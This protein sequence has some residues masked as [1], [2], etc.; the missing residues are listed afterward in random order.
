MD[1]L[2]LRVSLTAVFVLSTAGGGRRV[3]RTDPTGTQ[4]VPRGTDRGAGMEVADPIRSPQT[5]CSPASRRIA[6]RPFPANDGIST[7][8]GMHAS[9]GTLSD[10]HC[11]GRTPVRS[12]Q[13]NCVMKTRIQ[14]RVPGINTVAWAGAKLEGINDVKADFAQVPH[15]ASGQDQECW[16][17]AS[18]ASLSQVDV[19]DRSLDS[20]KIRIRSHIRHFPQDT[21]QM[22]S[23]ASPGRPPTAHR[24]ESP[25]ARLR[26]SGGARPRLL[27]SGENCRFDV[28]YK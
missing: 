5:H 26:H 11:P 13:G 7:N 3:K 16:C 6:F 25:C 15:I 9:R 18:T 22:S 2:A 24:E 10:P 17:R 1:V 20:G 8:S 12:P 21:L 4:S 27:Q 23:R 14:S 19:S 28:S